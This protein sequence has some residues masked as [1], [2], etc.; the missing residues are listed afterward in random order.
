M[1]TPPAGLRRP[2][3]RGGPACAT[4]LCQKC[5][6]RNCVTALAK[7]ALALELTTSA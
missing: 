6:P 7:I 3:R 1:P 4:G 2:P 5:S